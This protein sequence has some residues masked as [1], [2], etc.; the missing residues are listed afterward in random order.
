MIPHACPQVVNSN[1]N[2]KTFFGAM[3]SFVLAYAG[4]FM[5]L[6]VMSEMRNPQDFP[7]TFSIAGPYQVFMYSLVAITGYYYK[8]R[9]V[10]VPTPHLPSPCPT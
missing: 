5:Y 9:S 10:A 6:E 8:V 3:S 4:Q 7:K 1:L 2:I